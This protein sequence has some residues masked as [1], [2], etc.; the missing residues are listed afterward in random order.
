MYENSL[1]FS[2][3]G[4]HSIKV[5]NPVTRECIPYLANGK[6]TRYRESVQFLQPAGFLPNEGE[7]LYSIV[8][9]VASGW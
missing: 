2:D 1:M 8:P 7:C 6:G 5:F 9:Q 3:N 4:D